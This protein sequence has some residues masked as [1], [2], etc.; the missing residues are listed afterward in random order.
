MVGVDKSVLHQLQGWG[1]EGCLGVI[2]SGFPPLCEG[3]VPFSPLGEITAITPNFLLKSSFLKAGICR[4]KSQKVSWHNL[5]G[6]AQH[7]IQI[8]LQ[9]RSRR[10]D[11]WGGSP[12][13]GHSNPLQYS[14]LENPMDRGAWRAT[15]HR[16][17]KDSDMT[18]VT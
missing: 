15:V 8:R 9:P 7:S 4:R 17:H 2:M 3:Q 10:F 13:G 11:P 5:C 18:E 14:C 1:A 6:R 12:G 16:G